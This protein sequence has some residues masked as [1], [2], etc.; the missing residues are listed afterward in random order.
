M[1]KTYKICRRFRAIF[2]FHIVQHFWNILQPNFAV[3]LISITS[4]RKFPF[5]SQI[6]CLSLAQ[7]WVKA[8]AAL[9]AH[10][11]VEVRLVIH[12]KAYISGFYYKHFSH[13]IEWWSTLHVS[14]ILLHK[15][16]QMIWCCTCWPTST[17]LTHVGNI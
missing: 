17:R 14:T 6:K 2:K 4:L 9:V 3:L 10:R 16:E 7:P 8:A 12:F 1:Q 5:Y 11:M 13:L 15:S